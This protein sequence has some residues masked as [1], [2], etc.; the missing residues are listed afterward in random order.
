MVD[1][2]RNSNGEAFSR[3]DSLR[4]VRGAGITAFSAEVGLLDLEAPRLLRADEIL[5]DVRAAGVGHWD[6]IARAGGWDLGRLPPMALGVQAA[7]V[8]AAIG[9]DIDEFDAGAPVLVE[10]APF[11]DQGAWA[12]QFIVPASSAAALPA[13][14]AFDTAAGF[15]VPAL[16]ADQALRDGMGVSPGETVLVN[17]AGGVTGNLLVQ[18][19]AL[20]GAKVV[21]TASGQTAPRAGTCGAA[22]VLD[23]RSPDWRAQVRDWTGGKGV[24]AA[25]NAVPGKAAEVLDV[26][27]DDGKLATITSDPPASAR[28]VR[29]REVY[30]SPDGARLGRLAEMLASG[31]VNLEVT[32]VYPL[33]AAA[34]AL[35]HVRRGSRGGTIVLGFDG[36]DRAS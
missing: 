16:T 8:V 11:R 29:V 32:A 14:V 25:V 36:L 24:D 33:E 17:G 7:G 26:V 1:H 34:R 12:Q 15:P 23:Y 27:R 10:S 22:L 3:P 9:R 6:E 35:G 21:A 30:V 4:G 5:V 20:Y 19:A 18:F 31:A 28:G 13:R 2:A